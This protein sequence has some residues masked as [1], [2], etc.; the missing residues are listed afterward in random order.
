MDEFFYLSSGHDIFF[1]LHLELIIFDISYRLW[2]IVLKREWSV[3]N[4]NFASTT[5]LSYKY[6]FINC[7]VNFELF[8]VLSFNI[9]YQLKCIGSFI[10]YDLSALL[11]HILPIVAYR[12]ALLVWGVILTL[13]LPRVKV[14]PPPPR[15]F[16]WPFRCAKS[17]D[18]VA[19]WL[20]TFKSRA[21]DTIFMEI[22]HTVMTLHDLSHAL[23]TANLSKTQFCVQKQC[24]GVGF[25][26]YLIQT[27][28]IIFT[29]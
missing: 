28:M 21:S 29:G 3:K 25:F 8:G 27:D 17:F 12:K 11:Q 14:N 4:C 15:H 10:S 9:W 1:L 6:N 5:T 18:R 19:C 2:M 16:W 23:Q 7:T 22:G 13:K 26:F 20:F 24:T